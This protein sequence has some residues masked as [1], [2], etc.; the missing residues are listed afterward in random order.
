LRQNS[1]YAQAEDAE[2]DAEAND[3]DVGSPDHLRLGRVLVE[4]P[5]HDQL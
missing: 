3:A 4:V 2:E 5:E 1:G